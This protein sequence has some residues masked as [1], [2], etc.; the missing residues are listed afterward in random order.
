[1]TG[2]ETIMPSVPAPGAP[3]PTTAR[4]AAAWARHHPVNIRLS[5]PFFGR[6]FY[7]TIVS[8]GEKRDDARRDR[9][10]HHYPVRTASNVFFFIGTGAAFYA[11]ALVFMAFASSIIEW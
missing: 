4:V 3:D 9:D 7:L 6:R 5:V 10:R 11:V 1:M 8:G 2:T